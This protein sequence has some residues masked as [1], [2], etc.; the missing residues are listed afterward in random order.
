MRSDSDIERDV[1]DEL[2]WQPGLDATD[3]GV[4]VKDGV[5]ALTGFVRRYS[6]KQDAEAA[7]KRVAG[8]AGVAN[9]I[10]V[11]LPAV[12]QRPDPEIAREA[13]AAIKSRLPTSLGAHQGRRQGRLGR[14]RRRGPVA[15]PATCGGAGGAPVTGSQGHHQHDP[16][17]ALGQASGPWAQDRRSDQAKRAARRKPHQRRGER[18]RSDSQGQ[19]S[20][21]GTSAK[22]RN[23]WR[24]QRRVSRP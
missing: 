5:V 22:R 4:S 13:V 6:D 14:T 23:G 10:D 21:P 15:I 19:P 11:R 9:D 20:G 1:K 2:Q 18:R 24:G 12:D 17:K 16:N 3:V 7:A 8:V